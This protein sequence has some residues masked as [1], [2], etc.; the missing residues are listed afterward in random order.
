VFFKF[1]SAE[2][3]DDSIAVLD[4][5][6]ARGQAV[7]L[8]QNPAVRIEVA[9]HTDSV[10]NDAYNQLLSE[11]RANTVR[12]FLISR[13]VPADRLTVKGYGETDPIADNSTEEGRAKNR[14]VGLRIKKD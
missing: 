9:G 6:I 2:L 5:N 11:R 3:T 10:G 7:K 12:D 13:G 8:L 4:E 14:R 1:D